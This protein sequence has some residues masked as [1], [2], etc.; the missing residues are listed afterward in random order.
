MTK[1]IDNW[2][3]LNE[4]QN[5]MDA[6]IEVVYNIFTCPPIIMKEERD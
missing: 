6:E 1:S 5:P 4:F 2:L 3:D